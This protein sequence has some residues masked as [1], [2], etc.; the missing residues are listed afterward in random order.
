MFRKN[1]LAIE[2]WSTQNVEMCAERQREIL[3]NVARCVSPGGK[4]IYSTCTFSLEEN[5]MNVQWFLDTFR[6]FELCE[7]ESELKSATSDGICFEGCRYDM[8]KTRRFYPHVSK[9][10]GQFIA[11]MQR[12]TA[13]DVVVTSKKDKKRGDPQKKNSKRELE[14]LKLAEEFLKK[15]LTSVPQGKIKLIGEKLYICPDIALP[16][17]G[18]FCAGVCVGEVVKSRLVPH[19]QLFS[20]YGKDFCRRLELDSDD[21]RAMDYLCGA[22]ISANGAVRSSDGKIDGWAAVL[23]DG[24]PT[25]GGKISGGVCK[26]HYPKGIRQSR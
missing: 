4:L 16:D 21:K 13:E 26:N 20:A 12:K 10:E 5:E 2:E 11:V 22:E 7:A 9:G 6:D 8:K 23:I 3:N 19:H 25:G 1:S 14:A 15:E 18:M 17:F 24:V